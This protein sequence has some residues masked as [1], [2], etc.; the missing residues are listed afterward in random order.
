MAPQD[1]DI[2]GQE[3]PLIRKIIDDETWLEGERRNQ[4][5]SAQDQRV[6]E[7]V[8]RVV[9]Q[10]GADMRRALCVRRRI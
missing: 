6:V 2:V 8:C 3:I 7:N 9:L 1:N 4:P 5:V 10:V